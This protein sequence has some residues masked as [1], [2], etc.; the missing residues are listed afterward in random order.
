MGLP[1]KLNFRCSYLINVDGAAKIGRERAT[2]AR[3]IHVTEIDYYFSQSITVLL[4]RSSWS[5]QY[6]TELHT[7][8][9]RGIMRVPFTANFCLFILVVAAHL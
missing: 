4:Y 8:S 3:M 6:Q 1:T 9:I 7:L 2:R 5:I